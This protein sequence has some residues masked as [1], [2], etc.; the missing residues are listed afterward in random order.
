MEV[1]AFLY[2]ALEAC[3]S[4]SLRHQHQIPDQS[5]GFL[6]SEL[7]TVI[8]NL[9]DHF[10]PIVLQDVDLGP[11]YCQLFSDALLHVL[12]RA[13]HLKDFELEL[14]G[15]HYLGKEVLKQA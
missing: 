7:R 10:V 3:F 14:L 6:V 4:N 12:D 1:S 11:S 9:T 5:I 13:H 8:L 2:E 15:L